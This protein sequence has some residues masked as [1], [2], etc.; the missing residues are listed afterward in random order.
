MHMDESPVS[1]PQE[2]YLATIDTKRMDWMESNYLIA[3]IVWSYVDGVFNF[4]LAIDAAM[5]FT[6]VGG[7]LD[8]WMRV[9]KMLYLSEVLPLASSPNLSQ[10][11]S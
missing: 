3:S 6:N 5:K 9:A 10:E 1:G 11:Q 4:R 2:A 7:T 8:E